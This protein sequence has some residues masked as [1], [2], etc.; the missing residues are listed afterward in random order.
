MLKKATGTDK[1]KFTCAY[2]LVRQALIRTEE[3]GHVVF[4][5]EDI[6]RAEIKVKHKALREFC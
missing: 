5:L 6:D 3:D 4:V 2:K 1:T